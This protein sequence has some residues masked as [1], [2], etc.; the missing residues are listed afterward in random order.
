M[1]GY[2]IVQRVAG[3]R[4]RV[5]RLKRGETFVDGHRSKRCSVVAGL[6]F[7]FVS[8]SCSGIFPRERPGSGPS[9][10]RNPLRQVLLALFLA[11]PG[12]VI[13]AG[14]A[15]SGEPMA[16][17]TV[18]GTPIRDGDEL[19]LFGVI[20]AD[21]IFDDI[22]DGDDVAVTIT[23]SGTILDPEYEDPKNGFWNFNPGV[24][25]NHYTSFTIHGGTLTGD[26]RLVLQSDNDP[27]TGN[28]YHSVLLSI[29]NAAERVEVSNLIFRGGSWQNNGNDAS[30]VPEIGIGLNIGMTNEPDPSDVA[31]RTIVVRDVRADANT[32][33]VANDFT[34]AAS[35]TGINVTGMSGAGVIVSDVLY[36]RVELTGNHMTLTS[37]GS[38][39][40]AV[41]PVLRGGGSRVNSAKS[42]AYDGGAVVGNSVTL[43][44]EKGWAAGGGLSV[45]G[46]DGNNDAF[47]SVLVNNVT[48][49][50][51]HVVRKGDSSEASVG[52]GGAFFFGGYNNA[53]STLDIT[54]STFEGNTVTASGV[55]NSA[56]GGGASI[57]LNNVATTI[58]GTAFTGNGVV[59]EN[60][61]GSAS[62][63]AFSARAET[64]AFLQ[65][66]NSLAIAASSFTDNRAVAGTSARGG[67]VELSGGRG[68]S[69]TGTSFSGN[70]AEGADEAFGGALHFAA[71][72]GSD[73]SIVN[74]TF[75]GNT[76][77]SAGSAR[78]GA[79]HHVSGNLAIQGTGNTTYRNNAAVATGAG[80]ASGGAIASDSV[81]D[82]V[83]STELF[84][85]NRAT[86][87]AASGT[88]SGGGVF[89]KDGDIAL[90]GNTFRNNHASGAHARGGAV[91]I[92]SGATSDAGLV[93]NV[94]QGNSA[95]GVHSARGGAIA[96]S[97]T[98]DL[99]ITGGVLA[100]N[101]ASAS[102][103]GSSAYGGAIFRQGGNVHITD[104][105]ITGN[106]VSGGTALGA[107]IFMATDADAATP[108]SGVA[109]TLTATTGTMTVAN[110]TAGVAG[111]PVSRAAGP[112][113]A[114]IYFGTAATGAATREDGVFTIAAA[115]G[116]VLN[117]ED[118]VGVVL[119]SGKSFTQTR[120]GDGQVRL[121]GANYV[122]M[123][124]MS[125]AVIEFKG[126][127][128][129][130]LSGSYSQSFSGNGDAT[131][132]IEKDHQVT[133]SVPR[134]AGAGTALFDF[135]NSGTDG[136]DRNFVIGTDASDTARIGLTAVGEDGDFLVK[137]SS[138][139]IVLVKGLDEE[140]ILY[141]RDHF[142]SEPGGLFDGDLSG[143]QAVQGADGV[144]YLEANV[145]HH[146]PFENALASSPAMDAI[147]AYVNDWSGFNESGNGAAKFA[148]MYR[149][150]RAIMPEAF[151][152]QGRVM[153]D[154]V[155]V[156]AGTALR[157][158]VGR[159]G[160]GTGF[161]S[162]SVGD[163]F[164]S[165]GT[166]GDNGNDGNGA[167]GSIA[168]ESAVGML[169]AFPQLGG[170]RVWGGY[171]G[172]FQDR[173][174]E[175]GANG[176]KVD[177]HGFVAGFSRDVGTVGCVGVYGG[178]TSG[179][180][181]SKSIDGSVDQTT[182]HFGVI[183]RLNPLPV[184]RPGLAVFADVGYHFADNE[185]ERRFG[186]FS[187]KGSFDQT[188]FSASL[189]AEYGFDWN[190]VA[191]VPAAELRY[192]HLDQDD[193]T[194]AGVTATRADGFSR[195]WLTQRV[196]AE[197]SYLF[198]TDRGAFRPLIGLAWRHDY[199]AKRFTTNAAFIGPDDPILFPVTSSGHNRD[200]LDITA[201]FRSSH[202][203]NGYRVGV[204]V[205][206]TVNMG[207]KATVQ[208]VQAGVNLAF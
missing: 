126:N 145:V 78:G 49:T 189:G 199:G 124:D 83:V 86:A 73:N 53:G 69:I 96:Y 67:A 132:H 57:L 11:L 167:G 65:E 161:G 8:A 10:I 3:R 104:A 174:P 203:L 106:T 163:D 101:R 30:E 117:L 103:D 173:K 196:G 77:T 99:V 192:V 129:T 31:P 164:R 42:F 29:V 68:H 27:S 146:S 150:P 66:D 185:M 36:E 41:A 128:E 22:Q 25:G 158:G 172:S 152:D 168:S 98:D 169:P 148:A 135:T 79:I 165:G 181:R 171:V 75:E 127:G 85:N 19:E 80:S 130:I 195:S 198:R 48:F 136:G 119:N 113:G 112:A 109:L 56:L 50:D 58:S 144:W 142:V 131:I 88:A 151:V 15:V 54:G 2:T 17:A 51:N 5:V 14:A 180:V 61:G 134:E 39:A 43:E 92:A 114:G 94:F 71:L 55:N 140:Q 7:R 87:D 24:A 76:V 81:D 116:S 157:R 154:A 147:D 206:Y 89:K 143:M 18:N 202:L 120:D 194:E 170:W 20:W 190:G 183:G 160:S 176:Y 182:G 177:R 207:R 200:S 47:S 6:V 13:L 32:Y 70:T 37:T 141:I 137:S 162:G 34:T 179:D 91:D 100:D 118:S 28:P 111:G 90:S 121:G 122:V 191:I 159:R 105:D 60:G 138:Q 187:A 59:S 72:A 40:S 93:G 1:A 188:A 23:Q 82:L 125:S 178:F 139:D 108:G 133:I 149:N 74:S 97:G 4:P 123:D 44:S 102:G 33:L 84:E 184:A 38:G 204:D 156:V 115:R 62:G 21:V 26:D 45:D 46:G 52:R 64:A 197:A 9:R 153:I 95:E 193:M 201:G 208:S 35:G 110:G 186:G 205:E 175:D 16:T 166:G 107:G 155:D 12:A 63:G